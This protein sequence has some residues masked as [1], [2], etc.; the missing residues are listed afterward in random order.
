MPKATKKREKKPTQ[1]S[2]DEV[3]GKK[4]PRS[5]K[6][7][8]QIS[9]LGRDEITR[10]LSESLLPVVSEIAGEPKKIGTQDM[11]NEFISSMQEDLAKVQVPPSTRESHYNYAKLIQQHQQMEAALLPLVEQNAM[12]EAEITRETRDL[13]SDQAYYEE[14]KRNAKRQAQ[15]D[16]GGTRLATSLISQATTPENH[17]DTVEEIDYRPA[18]VKPADYNQDDDEQDNDA[19][20]T[21]LISTIATHSSKIA[22]TNTISLR[23]LVAACRQLEKHVIS[24]L[25]Q[26]ES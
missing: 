25:N 26:E 22:T 24:E 11:L 2:T 19:D 15:V 13:E 9:D 23:R 5:A 4:M 20:L 7:W 18:V 17:R 1:S 14:L 8:P 6:S 21:Q 16:L 3:L 10:I 12:L